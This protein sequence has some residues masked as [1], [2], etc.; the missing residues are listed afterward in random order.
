[1]RKKFKQLA[2]CGS[3]ENAQDI[4]AG[5]IKTHYNKWI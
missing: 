2:D 1:M 4:Y 3:K 5:Q